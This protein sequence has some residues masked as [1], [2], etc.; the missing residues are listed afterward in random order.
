MSET[1]PSFDELI[2]P[3][4]SRLQLDLTPQQRAQLARH[5]AT[6]R[7]WNRRINLTRITKPR[8]IA[9]RHF[10]ESL[11]VA[12]SIKEEAGTLL[13]VGSGAG[14]PGVPLGI[15]K[16]RFQVTLAEP[17]GKK[18]AFLKEIARSV[19]NITVFHGRLEEVESHFA[20][21]T[22]RALATRPLLKELA[23]IADRVVL[24]IGESDARD[25]VSSPLFGWKA[26]TRLPWGRERVLLMGH[27][28]GCST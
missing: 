22:V 1:E 17:V 7:R 16:P 13:D 26:P 6:L 24:L 4:L 3:V 19:E 9:E 11:F 23:R 10:G 15:T 25:I 12:K 5:F 27:K 28:P 8:E 18:V 2:G 14:F 21:A 20:W